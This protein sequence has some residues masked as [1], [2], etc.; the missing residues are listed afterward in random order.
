MGRDVPD[1]RLE[2]AGGEGATW[3]ESTW[4]TKTSQRYFDVVRSRMQA[5]SAAL[6]GRFEVNPTYL[7]KRVITVHSLGG[8]PMGN[9][10]YQGVVDR[11][12]EV[13]ESPGLYVVDGAAM[14]GPVG[15]NPSLTI[16]AFARWVCEHMR[17]DEVVTS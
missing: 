3:L 2:L 15:A 7:L 6:Q 16:A 14:P 10:P 8:S 17:T 11:Y 13:H 5:I 4:S 9:D 1:G 12:G